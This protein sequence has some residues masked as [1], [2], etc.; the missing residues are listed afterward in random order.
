MGKQRLYTHTH[1]HIHRVFRNAIVFVQPLSHVRLLVTPWTAICQVS[2]SFIISLSL[3]KSIS[4]E[5]VMLTI[6]SSAAP[7]SFCLQC[8]LASGSFPMSWFFASGGQS[9]GV[10]ASAS[11]L[12]VRIQ[13]WFPLGLTGLISMQSKGLSRVLSRTTLQKHQFFGAQSS[14]WSNSHICTWLLGKQELCQQS[15]V[16]VF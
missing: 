1:T 9:I 11:V 10:S 15:D 12:P 8:F 13:G 2:L 14:L 6:S 5:L 16:S 3:L 7:F 4:I